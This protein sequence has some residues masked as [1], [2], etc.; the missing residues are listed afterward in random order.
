VT[1]GLYQGCIGAPHSVEQAIP[2]HAQASS[3]PCMPATQ[4]LSYRCMQAAMVSSSPAPHLLDGGCKV[5][6]LARIQRLH[7]AGPE[8]GTHEVM[9]YNAGEG[10]YMRM[11][12]AGAQAEKDRAL[13]H[14]PHWPGHA[15]GHTARGT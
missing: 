5:S 9:A 2:P 13:S 7:L 11:H 10:Q 4:Q 12:L 6:H 8:R 14:T 15:K 3:P 1:V